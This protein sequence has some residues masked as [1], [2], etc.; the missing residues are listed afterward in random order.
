MLLIKGALIDFKEPHINVYI[1]QYMNII[2]CLYKLC[3]YIYIYIFGLTKHLSTIEEEWLIIWEGYMQLKVI[4][5]IMMRII[6]MMRGLV[7]IIYWSPKYAGCFEDFLLSI[8]RGRWLNICLE[9][10]SCLYCF[11]ELLWPGSPFL[12]RSASQF[13]TKKCTSSF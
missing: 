9:N 3:V 1:Y 4:Y 7:H 11:S 13:Y 8:P 12:C 2:I 10:R 6:V 5:V